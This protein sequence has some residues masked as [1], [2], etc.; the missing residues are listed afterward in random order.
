MA[1]IDLFSSSQCFD[2]QMSVIVTF[3]GHTYMF[4][5][6]FN[7]RFSLVKIIYF[8]FDQFL[9]SC[10]IFATSKCYD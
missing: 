7:L 3:L 6:T 5:S 10:I 2:G 8:I 1:V 4:M 9:Y